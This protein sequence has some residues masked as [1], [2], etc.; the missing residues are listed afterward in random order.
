MYSQSTKERPHQQADI[1]CSEDKLARRPISSKNP[2]ILV[3]IMVSATYIIA[4]VGL[5][6]SS[7]TSAHAHKHP[8]YLGARTAENGIYKRAETIAGCFEGKEG[9]VFEFFDP[10]MA[11]GIC[12]P[13]CIAKKKAS[14]LIS[15]TDCFCGELLP[16]KK[17]KAEDS[18]CT[19]KC[20]GFG[21]VMCK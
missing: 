12:A 8:S 7:A 13:A 4:L 9:H 6:A 5:L 16:R 21:E 19:T 10:Y 3:V 15:G 14:M 17:D 18:M 11:S 2:L 20:P 1:S